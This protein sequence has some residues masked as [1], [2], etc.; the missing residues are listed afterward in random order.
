MPYFGRIA[1][2]EVHPPIVAFP[3]RIEDL[4]ISFTVKKS[5]Q[6][7]GKVSANTAEIMVYN[8]AGSSRDNIREMH[9]QIILQAGYRE[10]QGLETLFQGT[11]ASVHHPYQLPDVV[12]KI[13]SGDGLKELREAQVTLSYAE[14]TPA[15]RVLSDLVKALG[16]PPKSSASLQALLGRFSGNRYLQGFSFS[17]SVKEG[18]DK[19]TKRLGFEYSIQDGALQVLERGKA[20]EA[21]PS[22]S[23]VVLTP[24]SGLYGSPERKSQLQDETASEKVPP[25]WRIRAALQPTL[26][27]GAWIA[28]ESREIR[29]ATAFKVESVEHRGDT[30]GGEW[31]TVFEVSDPGVP[32]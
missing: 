14:G 6:K 15:T 28:V 2:L 5:L 27:P 25:G 3:F 18:L 4:R 19:V 7:P 16:L 31:E 24:S 21:R 9:D 22:P 10:A 12:T 23:V 1:A 13:Q 26:S 20:L 11:V 32:L 8:L 17:G 29:R 30:H